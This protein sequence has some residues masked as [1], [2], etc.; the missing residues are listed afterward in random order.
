MPKLPIDYSKTIIYKIVCNDT[1]I[2]DCYVGH[3]TDFTRRKQIHKHYCNK[4]NSKNYNLK[5]YK[6]IREN[7][8]WNNWK[9]VMIEE[10]SCKNR[11]EA[12]KRE[13]HCLEVL[14][15]NLNMV[16][17]SRTIQEQKKEYYQEHKTDLIEK[18]KE[19]YEKHKTE[20]NE[21]HKEYYEKNRTEIIEKTKEYYEKNRTEIKEYQKVYHKMYKPKKIECPHC[22]LSMNKS[23]LKLH[24]RRKH[25]PSL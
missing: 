23:S 2:T 8:D 9:M 13:R 15:A 3:T 19:Y 6:T 1:N 14:Q 11:L 21:K 25:T 22:Y 16:I 10:I 17:P 5:V 12:T 20:I 18:S 24:I 7:G 4:K